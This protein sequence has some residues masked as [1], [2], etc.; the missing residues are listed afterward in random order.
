M[1]EDMTFSAIMARCLARVPAG[2]DKREGSIIYD[3]LAPAAAE[4]AMAFV[5]LS[6][7]KDDLAFPDTAAGENLTKKA[8]ERGVTR[9]TATKAKRKA[10]LK[11][12]GGGPK[13]VTLGVRFSGGGLNYRVTAKLA[14]GSYTVE[15]ETAGIVGNQY[16]GAL[17]PID[18]IQGLVTAELQDVLTP[19]EDTETDDALRKRYFSSLDGVAFGGNIKNYK[20][21]VT[22]I[23]GVGG[24]RVYPIWAGG[25]SVRLVIISSTWG[26]ATP[27]LVADVQTQIDPETNQ[28]RGDGIA[29]IGH[30]VTVEAVKGAITNITMALQYE[31][32]YNWAEL[33]T[34][35]EDTIKAYYAEL[36]A[37][38][39]GLD[40]ITVRVSQIET[41]VLALGGIVDVSDGKINGSA[42]NMVLQSDEIPVLGAVV[43]E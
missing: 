20:N 38:W 40:T 9:Y 36:A 31:S 30:T 41:R 12:S 15:C 17:V 22:A 26:I 14:A 25:G 39:D 18:F 16:F 5:E 28:G 24:V 13:D 34:P 33:Q 2:I 42:E 1:L 8:S 11:A 23:P 19:G 3:A 6:T 4:I 37:L 35:V 27:E 10:I 29:P 21:W 32:G 43:P 7:I